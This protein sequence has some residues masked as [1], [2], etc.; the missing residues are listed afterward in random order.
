MFKVKANDL[1][2][3]RESLAILLTAMHQGVACCSV[4]RSKMND[5]V[6]SWVLLKQW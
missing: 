3:S 5:V 4:P 2:T 6:L 1:V